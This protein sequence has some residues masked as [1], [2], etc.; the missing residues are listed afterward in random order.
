MQNRNTDQWNKIE[1]REIDSHI[2]G[3]SIFDIGPKTTQ[4]VNVI[5][6]PGYLRGKKQLKLASHQI[7]D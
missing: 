2:Y 7:K 1:N 5:V 4:C 6:T 3:Q